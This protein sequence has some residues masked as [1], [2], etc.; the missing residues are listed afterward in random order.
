MRSSM[1]YYKWA[2]LDGCTSNSA[3]RFQVLKE[4]LSGA[5]GQTGEQGREFRSIDNKLAIQ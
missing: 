3:R 4:L 2:N 1:S 5:D